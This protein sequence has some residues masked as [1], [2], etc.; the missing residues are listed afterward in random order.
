[1]EYLLNDI[2]QRFLK[3]LKG[4]GNKFVIVPSDISRRRLGSRD[5]ER[6]QRRT[7]VAAAFS[8]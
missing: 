4:F 8:L 1:M 5:A 6:H 7:H 3:V 2:A